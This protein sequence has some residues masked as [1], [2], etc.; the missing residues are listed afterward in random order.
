LFIINHRRFGVFSRIFDKN[1]IKLT[2]AHSAA[3]VSDQDLIKEAQFW[4]K[5]VNFVTRAKPAAK[6]VVQSTTKAKQPLISPATTVAKEFE[7]TM[8]KLHPDAINMHPDEVIN[9][10]TK[11]TPDFLASHV[12]R[13]AGHVI[14]DPA[15][16]FDIMRFG[17]GGKPI[18]HL[19]KW[20][21]ADPGYVS[22]YL[23]LYI[24]K[25][26]EIS[27]QH[28]AELQI[29]RSG[30]LGID[31]YIQIGGHKFVKP[32][33]IVEGL[34]KP[35][36]INAQN[37]K[38]LA[39]VLKAKFPNVRIGIVEGA[40]S[41]VPSRG[42]VSSLIFGSRPLR[43]MEERIAHKGW[44]GVI[45]GAWQLSPA[46]RE[47]LMKL[48]QGRLSEITPGEYFTHGL[49]DI[50][51][52]R[53]M[54]AGMIGGGIVHALKPGTSPEERRSRIAD[55]VK[56]GLWPVMYP[57]PLPAFMYLDAAI[58]KLLGGNPTL[59]QVPGAQ[60]AVENLASNVNY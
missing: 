37:A 30:P 8:F 55:A 42:I 34:E 58:G 50:G 15:H 27:P 1:M 16:P 3:R 47:F 11:N 57:L 40:E 52:G 5:L 33:L 45:T 31:K 13:R 23:H 20:Y 54:P 12:K 24:P 25:H 9:M 59:S 2:P 36:E 35:I 14:V 43:T 41:S 49:I 4:Q 28:L 53:L 22:K 6:K 38:R 39:A 26:M 32:L 17:E 10:A 51:L 19:Q 60:E 18:E 44:P 21:E 56:A 7:G 46:S 48:K 29:V